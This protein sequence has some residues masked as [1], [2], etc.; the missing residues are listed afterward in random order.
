MGVADGGESREAKVPSGSFRHATADLEETKGRAKERGINMNVWSEETVA[1]VNQISTVLGGFD[2]KRIIEIGQ[3]AD[4]RLIRCI[5]ALFRP[6]ELIGF[7]PAF[8]SQKLNEVASVRQDCAENNGLPDNCVDGIY[9]DCVFEH[10][11]NLPDLLTEMHRIMVPGGKLFAHFGPL[12]STSY[13]HHLAAADDQGRWYNY[14]TVRLPP[15][16]HLLLPQHQ[17]EAILRNGGFS[18]STAQAWSDFIFNSPE[19]NRLFFS[20]YAQ[21]FF[22]SPFEILLFKGYDFAEMRAKYPSELEY[23]DILHE[24]FPAKT[25]FFYDGIRVVLRKKA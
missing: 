5:S 12:W 23:I 3:H 4:A 16:C 1:W 10:V 21:I 18:Q 15:W 17:V 2:G 14:H 11:P 13:G 25:G 24:R 20:D 22:E 6:K 19:Q 8:P 7:N 9:S